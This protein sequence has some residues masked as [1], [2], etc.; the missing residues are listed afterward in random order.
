[1]LFVMIE[2]IAIS[3]LS[4]VF[5]ALLCLCLLLKKWYLTSNSNSNSTYHAYLSAQRCP[6]RHCPT[7]RKSSMHYIVVVLIVRTNCNLID[8]QLLLK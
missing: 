5:A 6:R 2:I 4:F 8:A 1:M 7:I 3:A